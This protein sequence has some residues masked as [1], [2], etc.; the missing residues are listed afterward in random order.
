MISITYGV[1]PLF[2]T[3]HDLIIE[4]PCEE[5]L[6]NAPSTE[7]WA[8]LRDFPVSSPIKTIREAMA[9]LILARKEKNANA[10]PLYVSAFTTVVLMH[11]VN[12]HMWTQL[13]FTQ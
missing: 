7:Q 9:A 2:S 13:Q 11:A 4:M 10:S 12:V 5:K 6:W 3:T 1:T 8:S